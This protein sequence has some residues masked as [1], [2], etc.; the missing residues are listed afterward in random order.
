VAI[1]LVIAG[2]AWSFVNFGL[3]LWLP[4]ELQG[5]GYSSGLANTIIASSALIA[6][7]TVAAAAFLYSR[8]SSKWTLV[9]ALVLTAASLAATLFV[10]LVSGSAALMVAIVA[11]LIIGSNAV[12]AVLLPYAAENY[13]LGV[14]GR[15]TGTVAAASKLGG[16]AVQGSA[17]L[18]FVPAFGLAALSLIAPIAL[19]ALLVGLAGPETCGR[20]LRD[21]EKASG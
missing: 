4:S 19:A 2:L 12:L 10:D 5:R 7:P 20:A 16:V 6:L 18:G 21:L 1:A 11:S 8:W 15:G 3:L 14:R 9:G 13:R 17:L